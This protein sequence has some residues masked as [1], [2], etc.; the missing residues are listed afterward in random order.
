MP[1]ATNDEPRT[2]GGSTSP[3]P[4][5]NSQMNT[6][7]STAL[8]TTSQATSSDNGFSSEAQRRQAFYNSLSD[9]E[10]KAFDEGAYCGW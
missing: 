9:V 10:R 3:T 7:S 4:A 6:S 8:T 2:N 1:H 5:T